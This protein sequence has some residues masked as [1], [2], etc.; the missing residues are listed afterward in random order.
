MTDTDETTPRRER[1]DPDELSCM[2][3]VD[4]ELAP[5]ARA[6]LERRMA[7]EPE[8]TARVSAYR[9]LEVLA[10]QVAPAEPADHEWR[11]L[12]REGVQR[13]GLGVGWTLF[14]G[15]ALFFYGWLGLELF[16]DDE[17]ELVP[18]LAIAAAVGGFG[19]LLGMTLRARLKTLPHDPYTEVER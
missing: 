9:K 6:E 11:R 4:D 5:D 14:V 16:R 10:R 13:A 18:K 15:G 8:L 19:I 3:Y 12:D 17:L 1:P 2:A 7:D